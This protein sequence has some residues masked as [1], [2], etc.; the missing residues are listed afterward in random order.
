MSVLLS[1]QGICKTLQRVELF[2]D[3][4][5]GIF[6]G[7]KIGLI[8]PNGVG[9]STLLK[10]LAGLE[11]PDQGTRALR[12]MAKMSL[13]PQTSVFQ[14]G[15]TVEEVVLESMSAF[16]WDEEEKH[17]QAIIALSRVGFEE[18]SQEASALSGGWKKRL[19]IACALAIDPDLVL[20]DEP[21]NHLDIE[22]ILWLEDL[23]RSAPFAFLMVT[24]DRAF[25]E[26]VTT[27]I[28]EI[29]R[30]YPEGIFRCEGPYSTFL[31]QRELF[32]SGQKNLQESLENRVRREQEWLARGPKARTTKAKGRIAEAERLI[33]ELGAMKARQKKGSASLDF[34]SSG[35]QT[36]ELV[37]VEGLCKSLGGKE[38]FDG[39]SFQITQG[40]KL[41]LLG[42][43]G[44][45]KSTLLKLIAGLIEADAGQ[46]QKADALRI[47]YFEQERHTLDPRKTLR[48]GLAPEGDT[49]FF[50][51]RSIHVSTWAKRFLFRTEQLDFEIGQLSGGEQARLRLAQIILQ[52]ADLLLLDEP[53]NDL[54]IPTLEVLEENLADFPGALVLVTHDRAML[55]HLADLLLEIDPDEDTSIWASLDQWEIGR[56]ERRKAKASGSKS[57][58]AGKP[59]EITSSPAASPPP[60]APA[61]AKKAL[62][63]TEKKELAQIEATILDAE[64]RLAECQASLNDPAVTS[65]AKKVEAAFQ[66][67]QAAQNDVE[68]LYLRWNELEARK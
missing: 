47:V 40:M 22:G 52:P 57:E 44:S 20:L 8:G 4:S 37:R 51:G 48:R 55:D 14:A 21:T 39:L 36:K 60:K 13:V 49:V 27:A 54:D 30:V 34:Q 11:P 18:T 1:C 64:A 24:H 2:R 42:K 33:K 58:K 38:L 67:F 28:I 63:Y 41:G 12:K 9:K 35:R 29:D 25:L 31:E 45:G 68:R 19:S 43:N 53:T 3:L 7:D 65:D 15:K 17:T 66:A 56:R 10:I 16:S 5:L 46:I 32:L 50:R 6:E 62:S 59:G 26:R 61:P 23:L